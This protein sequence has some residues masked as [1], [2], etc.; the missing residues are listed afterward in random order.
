[1]RISD[2]SSDVFSSDLGPVH[3]SPITLTVNEA[4]LDAIGSN[5]AST[6]EVASGDLSFT[7]RSD[8]LSGFA[9][10]GVAG[11]AANLD[12]AGTAIF[13][14][15][16]PDGQTITGSLTPGGPAAIPIGLTARSEDGRGGKRGV[17]T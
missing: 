4:A 9:F 16:A 10:T 11:L 14:S 8:T 3:A 2:W 6:A 1:M 15:M 12:G 17:G 5:P 7:A 13:W